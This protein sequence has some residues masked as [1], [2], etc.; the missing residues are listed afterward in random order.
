MLPD[1][2]GGFGGCVDEELVVCFVIILSGPAF[3][4]RTVLI[5]HRATIM[6]WDAVGGVGDL[7]GIVVWLGGG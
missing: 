2:P 1:G 7:E 3:W 5:F 6:R 4:E